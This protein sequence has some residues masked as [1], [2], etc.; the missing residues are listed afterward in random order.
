MVNSTNSFFKLREERVQDEILSFNK[1]IKISNLRLLECLAYT[2]I[3][4]VIKRYF[5]DAK[6]KTCFMARLE[7]L[8]Y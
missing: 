6:P 3:A 8:R 4:D 7:T 5:V 1:D 2:H